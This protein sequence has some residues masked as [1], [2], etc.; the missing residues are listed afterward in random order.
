[1][2]V[3]YIYTDDVLQEFSKDS[4]LKPI[5]EASGHQLPGGKLVMSSHL[6]WLGS[7]GKDGV[8]TVRA[9]GNLDRPSHLNA[10]DFKRGGASDL[11]FTADSY[12]LVSVGHDGSIVCY[13]WK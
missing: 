9:V 8:L 5:M 4:Y 6:K 12:R 3:I 7:V 13:N 10:H 2:P 1:M 11:A